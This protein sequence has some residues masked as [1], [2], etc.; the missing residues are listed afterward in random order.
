MLVKIVVFLLKM[1]ASHYWVDF[2]HI[3]SMII[4][5]YVKAYF[6]FYYILFTTQKA[7]YQIYN[8]AAGTVDIVEYLIHFLGL[9]TLKSSYFL[10]LPVT[11]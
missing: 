4:Q 10:Y 11:K 5:S 3:F 6:Y 1:F 9:L 8:V 7:L 2:F